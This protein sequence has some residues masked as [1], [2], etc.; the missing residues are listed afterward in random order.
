M[1]FLMSKMMDMAMPDNDMDMPSTAK[2]L[3]AGAMVWY[4]TKMLME[5]LMD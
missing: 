5:E 1:N 3:V 2:V 4:G